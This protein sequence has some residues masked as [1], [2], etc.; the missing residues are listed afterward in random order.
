MRLFILALTA[1]LAVSASALAD[2]T[3]TSPT[4]GQTVASPFTLSASAPSCSSQPVRSIGYSIDNSHD[5]TVIRGTTLDVRVASSIGKHKV[6]VKAWAVDGS[7]CVAAVAVSVSEIASSALAPPVH[8]TASAPVPADAIAANHLERLDGWFAAHDSSGDGNSGGEMSMVASPSRSGSARQFVTTYSD[9]GDERYSVFFGKE[10]DSTHFLY[11]GWVYLDDSA[12][13]IANLELDVNQTMQNGQ[14]VIFGI[15]CD[16]YANRWDYTE[17]LGTPE[18]PRG[19]WTRTNAACNPRKWSRNQWHHI[20]FTY[21][22]DDA[23]QVTYGS[24]YLDGT[25]SPINATV[26]GAHALGWRPNLST[27]FQVDG[28][29]NG[30]TITA[31]LDD[32]TIYRW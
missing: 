18:Q 27:N 6:H 28:R 20:Q 15:Q 11:D 12:S 31:Y 4:N 2:V 5:T 16:G 26:L 21:S 32:L 14:T 8:Q 29:G 9:S 24:I 19:N 3:I 25:E 22:R 1:F 10:S 17:N 7:V 13:Q 23:G 30:G